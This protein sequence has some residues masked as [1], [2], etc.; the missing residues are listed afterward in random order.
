MDSWVW[1]TNKFFLQYFAHDWHQVGENQFNQNYLTSKILPRISKLFNKIIFNQNAT[2]LFKVFLCLNLYSKSGE[3]YRCSNSKT[4]KLSRT[5]SNHKI[6]ANLFFLLK[7][8]S[9]FSMFSTLSN[10]LISLNAIST[11]T[12]YESFKILLFRW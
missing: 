11:W 9:L 10:P 6:I 8:L 5:L 1:R 7:I 12:R 2:V 3:P 4:S